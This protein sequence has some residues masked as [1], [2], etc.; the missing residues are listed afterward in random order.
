MHRLFGRGAAVV[1]VLAL[2]A[3]LAVAGQTRDTA[4]GGTGYAF[5]DSGSIAWTDISGTG[6]ISAVTDDDD[7]YESDVPI[8]FT[9]NFG[10]TDYT[11]LEV[12]TNGVLSLDQEGN[13]EYDKEPLPTTEWA[14]PAL[15]SWWDDLDPGECGDMYYETVGSAPNRAF[16]VQWNDVCHNDCE[17]CLPGEGITIEVA[18]CEGTN[19]IVYQYLDTF[20]GNGNTDLSDANDGG[21]AA[22]G[23]QTD[24]LNGLEYSNSTP[25]ITDDLAIVFY[26][27]AGSAVNCLA[28]APP[29]PT[30]TPPAT[31][32]ADTPV[33]GQPTA[34]PS[35]TPVSTQAPAALPDTG[36]GSGGSTMPDGVWAIAALAAVA[37]L[38]GI[39][40]AWRLRHS[41]P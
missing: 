1:S 29:T 6:T 33:P 35:A 22:V 28:G 31:A 9:F 32:P 5:D 17:D 19:N 16:I 10:G 21:S 39:A 38:A 3:F 36:G 25:V 24:D 15:F 11:I 8:G 14:G 7:N 41:T 30:S 18:L 34:T 20:F 40:G 12:T 4:A 37:G 27:Q 13:D 26:P 23:L 2:I